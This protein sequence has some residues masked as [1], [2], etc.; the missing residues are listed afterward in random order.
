MGDCKHRFA[1]DPI[2][3][4]FTGREC[5][6]ARFDETKQEYVIEPWKERECP[7]YEDS[8]PVTAPEALE[9]RNPFKEAEAVEGEV[10]VITVCGTPGASSCASGDCGP[11][12]TPDLDA[13]IL[14]TLFNRKYGK[15]SVRVEFLDITSSEVEKYPD[16][17][18]TL[19]ATAPMCWCSL[20][21]C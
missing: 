21:G 15:G 20:T 2:K 12:E 16:V 5:F 11:E 3:C 4:T 14:Q 10:P 8:K 17:W 19:P 6:G 7:Q 9:I 18:I 13:E 1:E